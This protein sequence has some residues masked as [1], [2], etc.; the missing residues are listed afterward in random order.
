MVAPDVPAVA[1]GYVLARYLRGVHDSVRAVPAGTR[2]ERRSRAMA[3]LGAS[4][5]AAVVRRSLH[6]EP[7]MARRVLS[8]FDE[9]DVLLQPGPSSP[10]SRIGAYA[11]A[12]ALRTLGAAI[13]KVPFL[14]L[15]NMIGNP[16]LAAPVFVGP[17]GLPAGVQLVG[18]PGGERTLLRLALQLQRATGWT[19]RRPP[20]P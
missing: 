9:V 8:I 20:L 2:L 19:D 12:G 4:V 5:P 6:A 1:T 11:G 10:P 3:R 17:D 16:V 13:A 14:P 7:A 18:A 15:W